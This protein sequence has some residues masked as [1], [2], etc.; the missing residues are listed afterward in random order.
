MG[1]ASSIHQWS[2]HRLAAYSQ[3]KNLPTYVTNVISKNKINGAAVLNFS[4]FD[5][6]RL[7][8]NEKRRKEL[9][10][11]CKMIQRI[12][13]RNRS[14]NTS[15]DD[16]ESQI[17]EHSNRNYI[18]SRSPPTDELCNLPFHLRNRYFTGR[19][20]DLEILEDAFFHDDEKEGRPRRGRGR[21]RR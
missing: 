1:T 5:L 17:S 11:H 2:F 18:D 9:W 8:R 13:S 20:V 3:Q 19:K 21:R 14:K 12:S 4:E 16:T 10:K 15:N 7:E 6:S